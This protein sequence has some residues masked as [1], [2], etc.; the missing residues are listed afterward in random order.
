MFLPVFLQCLLHTYHWRLCA[1]F[2]I[3]C[4]ADLKSF[5]VIWCHEVTVCL[6]FTTWTNLACFLPFCTAGERGICWKQ[7]SLIFGLLCQK[8][9]SPLNIYSKLYKTRQ[10][11]IFNKFRIL[12]TLILKT[13]SFSADQPSL[14]FLKSFS[15]TV[16]S[17]IVWRQRSIVL[18]LSRFVILVSIMATTNPILMKSEIQNLLSDLA[19]ASQKQIAN[20]L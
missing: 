14:F 2:D 15:L 12:Q 1:C 8:L 17:Q 16:R 11:L 3:T 18:K 5:G 10:E 20:P 19:A 7:S 6:I 9:E 4:L 13:A